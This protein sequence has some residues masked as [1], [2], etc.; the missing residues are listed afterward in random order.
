ML[1]FVVEDAFATSLGLILTPGV[2]TH[3]VRVGTP[4]RLVRPDGTILQTKIS[5]NLFFKN[6][7]LIHLKGRQGHLCFPIPGHRQRDIQ[8][9]GEGISAGIVLKDEQIAPGPIHAKANEVVCQAFQFESD[10]PF[11]VRP[12]H[13]L[14]PV[15]AGGR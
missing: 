5:R 13:R 3:P 12:F 4:I 9:I 15:L 6:E 1:L 14:G 10:N 8:T 2:G 7:R 11:D